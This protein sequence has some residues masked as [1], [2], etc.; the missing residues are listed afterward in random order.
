MWILNSYLILHI[1]F[2]ILYTFIHPQYAVDIENVREL[3]SKLSLSY[4]A[5]KFILYSEVLQQP[6]LQVIYPTLLLF[7]S[8]I[9][10]FAILTVKSPIKR[11]KRKISKYF[12]GCVLS[13]F[14]MQLSLHIYAFGYFIMYTLTTH[15]FLSCSMSHAVTWFFCTKQAENAPRSFHCSVKLLLFKYSQLSILGR[16][17]CFFN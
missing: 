1:K 7:S 10:Y 17:N 14:S 13:S 6:K 5:V 2:I 16:I 4:I 15:S 11:W 9:M 3:P 12:R 8:Y